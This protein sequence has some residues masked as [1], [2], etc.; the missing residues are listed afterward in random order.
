MGVVKADRRNFIGR[1]E[2]NDRSRDAKLYQGHE[3]IYIR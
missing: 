2:Q 1:R 3:A